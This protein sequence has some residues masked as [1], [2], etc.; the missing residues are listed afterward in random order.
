[1]TNVLTKGT[2]DSLIAEG[3]I[4]EKPCQVT[5]DTMASVTVARPDIVAG[6]PERKL[7]QP[8]VLQMASQRPFLS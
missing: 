5:I 1:V 7:S 6:Q 4:Q 8:C 3:W 2:E